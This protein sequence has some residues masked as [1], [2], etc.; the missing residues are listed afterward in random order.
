MWSARRSCSSLGRSVAWRPSSTRR[1]ASP[2]TLTPSCGSSEHILGQV[3]IGGG[4]GR[5]VVELTEGQVIKQRPTRRARAPGLERATRRP[6]RVSVHRSSSSHRALRELKY[7]NVPMTTAQRFSAF[8]RRVTRGGGRRHHVARAAGGV[9][10]YWSRRPRVGRGDA[11]DV[12]WR[13]GA[14]QRGAAAWLS[15]GRARRLRAAA[16][17]PLLL[18][19]IFCQYSE[20]QSR[21]HARP[22]ALGLVRARREP[23]DARWGCGG[24]PR[25]S[26]TREREQAGQLVLRFPQFMQ[27]LINIAY[28]RS[29]PVSV[30][31]AGRSKPMPLASRSTAS[32][33]TSSRAMEAPAPP[34][35]APTS[36]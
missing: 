29:N 18:Q 28:V 16:H 11:R 5:Q 8:L 20:Q 36:Q 4:G 3:L 24:R 17:Q 31:S 22:R 34:A 33:S 30:L 2:S 9:R 14:A 15:P 25:S 1:R 26:S 7:A 35:P 12:A 32:S 27:A 19:D 10:R 21:W 6:C 13:V 23:R